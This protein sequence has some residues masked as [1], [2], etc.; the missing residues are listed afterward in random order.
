MSHYQANTMAVPQIQGHVYA[1]W[2]TSSV[3]TRFHTPQEI[4]PNSPPLEMIFHEITKKLIH[5]SIFCSLKSNRVKPRIFYTAKIHF[6]FPHFFHKR[7]T[8]KTYPSSETTLKFTNNQ[9][10]K[11]YICAQTT[12]C[13]NF[14]LVSHTCPEIGLWAP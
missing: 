13:D 5:F 1:P 6:H 11:K 12:K 14:T 10:T 4:K 8:A 2:K 9:L 7:A 3:D